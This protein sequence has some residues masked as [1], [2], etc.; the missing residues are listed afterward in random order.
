[1]PLNVARS[2]ICLKNVATRF[3]IDLMEY[4]EAPLSWSVHGVSVSLPWLILVT[5]VV[6]IV[7]SRA[8][9]VHLVVVVQEWSKKIEMSRRK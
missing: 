1:M 5:I 4:S 2:G 9:K 6:T 3:R 8:L 7:A